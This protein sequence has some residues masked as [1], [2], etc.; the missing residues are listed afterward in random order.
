MCTY[1]KKIE[2]AGTAKEVEIEIE[3]K[4]KVTLR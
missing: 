2:Y 1:P 3:I 4:T